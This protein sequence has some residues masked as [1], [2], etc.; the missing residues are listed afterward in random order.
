MM[1]NPLFLPRSRIALIVG[2]LLLSLAGAN[3]VRAQDGS[4]LPPA[5]ARHMASSDR[6]QLDGLLD[7]AVWQAAPVSSGFRQQE[8]D[9]GAPATE[10]TEVRVVYDETTLYV[11]I[12]AYD[13]DPDAVIARVLQRDRVMQGAGFGRFNFTTDDGV[14][15]L[16]DTFHDHR[17]AMVFATNPNGAEFDALISDEGG[18]VN[19]D[20]RGVWRV[21]AK[22]TA[23]GWSAEFAIPF[24]TLRYPSD[25]AAAV[26]GFNVFRS[27]R[28]KNEDVLWRS[29]SRNN[30]GFN[31]VSRAGHLEGLGDLPRTDLNLE[32]KP[33][34]LGGAAQ[35]R[36]ALGGLDA[37]G[38]FDVGFD[39]KYEI[40]PGLVLDATLNTDFAQVEADDEQVNL[41]RFSLF[42]P[43][44]RDFFLE[45]SGIFEFGERGFFGPPPYLLFF[46]R[47][48]GIAPEGEVPVLGGLRLTGRVGSQR[49]GAL[50]VVTD[51]AF[52]RPKTNFAVVR[53]KRDIG[54]NNFIGA[55]V[56]DRR[57]SEGWNT[58]GGVDWSFW[59]TSRLVFR[60]FASATA[61]SGAGGEG[62]AFQG[63]LDYT[64]N[65]FGFNIAHLSISPDAR[66][67]MGFITRTDVRQSTAFFR[68]TPRPHAVGLRKVDVFWSNRLITRTDGTLQ[69]WS[70]G[71]SF[72]P[73]W[74]SGESM[75][76]EYEV[77]FTRL[78]R[79]F[80]IGEGVPVP[81]GD[82]DTWLISASAETSSNRPVVLQ[83]NTR[84]QS[85]Y[86]GHIST[87]GGS[88]TLR[89]SANL[90]TVLS[91]TH[92]RVDVPN[93]AFD[94]DIGS[95]RLTL[96]FTTQITANALIQY[97]ERD[98]ELSANIRFNFIHTPG[99]DLFIVL[100]EQ[101][102][103]SESLW[104][105]NTRST[106]VKITYLARL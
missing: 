98:D 25:A 97:N 68:V 104:D 89:P 60:G 19:V 6:I 18:E 91:Y 27:I 85:I 86:D 7:E 66:A 52:G 13:S 49:V 2:S 81:A 15:I 47:R 28:R 64:S 11:G 90:S 80:E 70:I 61:T 5:V 72:S 65:Y 43:E 38:Q 36:N 29:W 37:D 87:V 77:G 42:F 31:R 14:A 69:D 26:W 55:L 23:D 58:T 24:R 3:Q 35:M 57:T 8:P 16:F 4:T 39:A 95:L 101:R 34:V 63:Q 94:A 99:S 1:P 20:W 21:A 48:I 51:D 73:Q 30:E 10:R 12:T 33:Y 76:I 17:N 53:V 41:T 46:S 106:V 44:K 100:N 105:L 32:I 96:A 40:R 102:G 59:P 22:R 71:P 88:L 54:T 45:N 50:N 56:T 84:F 82:Y 79:G 67:D 75:R 92:N 9:E 62:S 78:D 103:T 83:G 93:G 74:N